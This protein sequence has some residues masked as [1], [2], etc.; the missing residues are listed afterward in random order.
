MANPS[1][2]KNHLTLNLKGMVI[3]CDGLVNS[4]GT[5]ALLTT[6]GTLVA[7]PAALTAAA[8]LAGTLGGTANTTLEAT[9]VA[10][11]GVDGTGS[12]AASKADVDTR[13]TAINNNF[14]DLQTQH[15]AIAADL[16]VL[17]TKIVAILDL[18]EAQGAMKAS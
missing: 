10:V 11:T 17:R 6:P 8:T 5:Y 14:S 18:L 13:L 9:G 7:D 1:L 15:A 12:N 3:K 4:A 16:D 2:P